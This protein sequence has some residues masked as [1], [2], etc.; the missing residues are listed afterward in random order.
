MSLHLDILLHISVFSCHIAFQCVLPSG[1]PSHPKSSRLPQFQIFFLTILADFILPDELGDHAVKVHKF[2]FL[3]GI[4]SS[5]ITKLDITNFPRTT[6]L[7]DSVVPFC[8]PVKLS[9]V[10][11]VCVK[12]IPRCFVYP[13]SFGK[14]LFSFI[15]YSY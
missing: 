6:Y 7:V 5:I 9:R 4:T 8:P 2:E 12:S 1:S 3:I 10:L 11:Y 13:Y 15:L 14:Y